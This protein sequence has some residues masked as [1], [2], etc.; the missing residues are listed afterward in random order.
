M[1][2]N[3]NLLKYIDQFETNV[4]TLTKLQN[5]GIY[6][7]WDL[8]CETVESLEK[9]GIK[10]TKIIALL[11]SEGL[12]LQTSKTASTI[13]KGLSK[14]GVSYLKNLDC[15][16]FENNSKSFEIIKNLSK[17]YFDYKIYKNFEDKKTSGI[18]ARNRE[19]K[20]AGEIET[21]ER[22]IIDQQEKLECSSCGPVD[23]LRKKIRGVNARF[24]DNTAKNKNEN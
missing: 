4:E 6:N 12:S 11:D 15:K 5:M 24:S 1:S 16:Y 19:E 21:Y 8:H 3:F 20:I 17:Y 14:S 2:F 7:L 10:P 23:R 13:L 22:V 9:K 18:T